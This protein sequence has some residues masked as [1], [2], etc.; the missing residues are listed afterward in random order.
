M[1][2]EELKKLVEDKTITLPIII[3]YKNS[4]Y[5]VGVYYVVVMNINNIILLHEKELF[6]LM[7][8]V[9]FTDI[10][11]KTNGENKQKI[12]ISNSGEPNESATLCGG[13]GIPIPT[14]K[15]DIL[16]STEV[17]RTILCNLMMCEHLRL[18][19]IDF[20]HNKIIFDEN[21]YK[22][23]YVGE[24][25]EKVIFINDNNECLQIQKCNLNRFFHFEN[26]YSFDEKVMAKVKYDKLL[27]DALFIKELYKL[28]A[29][30]K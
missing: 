24:R 20:L 16:A 2:K 4:K 6:N 23:E 29:S 19:D 26:K 15:N 9:T 18:P 12:I 25:K 13:V 5:A 8:P 3:E 1:N 10:F 11:M 7:S 22:W 28:D 21:I 27:K 30:D 14:Y 17:F